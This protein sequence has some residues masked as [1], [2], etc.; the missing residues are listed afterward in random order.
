MLVNRYSINCFPSIPRSLIDC[1]SRQFPWTWP[2]YSM[3]ILSLLLPH[4]VFHWQLLKC[5]AT[6][7][8]TSQ[9]ETGNDLP[10]RQILNFQASQERESYVSWI[11]NEPIAMYKTSVITETFRVFYLRAKIDLKAENVDLNVNK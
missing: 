9:M 8:G 3:P 5:G 1:C 4:V 7:C 6:S 10:E 11:S 2:I